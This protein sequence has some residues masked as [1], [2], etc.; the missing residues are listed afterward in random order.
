M[1]K[2]EGGVFVNGN[3]SMY[4]SVVFFIVRSGGDCVYDSLT[5]TPTPPSLSLPLSLSFYLSLSLSLLV[6][7]VVGEIVVGC[8]KEA[9]MCDWDSI[10]LNTRDIKLK[11]LVIATKFQ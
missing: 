5:P 2:G 3:D 8:C 7:C 6:D 4:L 1:V 10:R 9:L 11:T